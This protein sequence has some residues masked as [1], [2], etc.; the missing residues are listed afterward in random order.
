MSVA[1][2]VQPYVLDLE[3]TNACPADCPMCPREKLPSLGI[4]SEKTFANVLKFVDDAK[5]SIVV[6]FCGIGEPLLHPKIFDYIKM[7]KQLEHKPH[8]M[9]VTAGERLTPEVFEKLKELEVDTIN[10]SLQT[11][12]ENLYKKLM[13]GLKL[14]KVVKN[15]EYISQNQSEKMLFNI[16][17][18]VHKMNEKSVDD[19]LSFAK[20]RKLPV[21]LTQIH[22][23]GGNLVDDS[24]TDAPPVFNEPLKTCKIFESINFISWTGDIH[25]CCQDIERINKIGNVNDDSMNDLSIRKTELLAKGLS[26]KICTQCNDQL[27]S[28]LLG[29]KNIADEQQLKNDQNL[30]LDIYNKMGIFGENF[31]T[32][33][34]TF[35]T[36][37]DLLIHL[38]QILNDVSRTMNIL[39]YLR[40]KYPH[41]SLEIKALESQTID[42]DILAA[43]DI[44]K[45]QHMEQEQIDHM[46]SYLINKYGLFSE[47][48]FAKMIEMSK[49]QI[50]SMVYKH[51]DDVQQFIQKDLNLMYL[52]KEKMNKKLIPLKMS[53]K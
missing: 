12:D 34:A 50:I 1:T 18:T 9:I 7:L 38:D 27:R 19:I 47:R 28:S 36:P 44:N 21:K 43:M 22:S 45:G 41:L 11:L 40:R 4:M 31:L 29:E 33:L 14:E 25:P 48:I 32:N 15:I 39:T 2:R 42:Q 30:C 24:L 20:A 35:K 16:S 8:I 17:L 51:F 52:W 53:D 26:Y 23:R 37:H 46:F 10:L 5:R 6:G 49:Q 13:P 3:I